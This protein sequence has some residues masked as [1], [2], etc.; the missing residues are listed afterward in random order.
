MLYRIQRHTL[1]V[2]GSEQRPDYLF[3]IL[4]DKSFYFFDSHYLCFFLL[5][6]LRI[7]SSSSMVEV[8]WFGGFFYLRG[9]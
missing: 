4:Y 2:V 6:F 8:F 1:F 7:C 3:V 5:V 9:V